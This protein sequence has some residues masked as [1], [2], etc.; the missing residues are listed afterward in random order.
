MN[1]VMFLHPLDKNCI[2]GF[3][4]QS[5]VTTLIE[6]THSSVQQKLTEDCKRIIL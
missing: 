5:T 1:A 6:L 4:Q 3:H 2:C